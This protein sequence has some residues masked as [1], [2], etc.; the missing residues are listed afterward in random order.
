MVGSLVLPAETTT[1]KIAPE[2]PSAGTKGGIVN[3]AT[4]AVEHFGQDLQRSCNLQKRKTEMY[5]TL[6]VDTMGQ[7]APNSPSTTSPGAGGSGKKKVNYWNQPMD[8]VS[9]SIHCHFVFVLLGVCLAA[10]RF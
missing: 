2:S 7:D 9:D 8:D 10:S 6:I 4:E 1:S 5:G 3:A